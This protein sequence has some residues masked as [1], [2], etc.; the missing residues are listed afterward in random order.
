V[1]NTLPRALLFLLGFWLALELV[2]P[3]AP[4]ARGEP[5]AEE[6]ALAGLAEELHRAVNRV[7]AE[8]HLVPLAREPALDR[9]ALAHSAD[10]AARGYLAHESP[11]GTTPVDRIRAAGAT[12]FTLAAENA[13]RTSRGDAIREIVQGWLHSPIHRRNLLLPAF[14]AGGVGVARAPDGSLYFTQ[15]YVARPRE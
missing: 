9:A 1:P 11:E 14:N 7:R 5:L 8:H 2:G 15:V 10:M 3:L 12:G 6:P 4:P 13:G